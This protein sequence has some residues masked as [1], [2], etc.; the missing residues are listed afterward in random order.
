MAVPL[1]V[2][3]YLSSGAGANLLSTGEGLL[4]SLTG[5]KVKPKGTPFNVV[6]GNLPKFFHTY[7]SGQIGGASWRPS[8]KSG[9]AVFDAESGIWIRNIDAAFPVDQRKKIEATA[10]KPCESVTG[11]AALFMQPKPLQDDR[12]I[13]QLADG[14][15]YDAAMYNMDGGTLSKP[16]R[17]NIQPKGTKYADTGQ[18]PHAS[19]SP[20]QAG[21]G[22]LGLLAL[23]GLYFFGKK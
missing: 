12:G 14:Q 20:L 3:T 23:A 2:S 17:V 19:P 18:I 16:V 8:E 7:G 11:D 9:G 1:M 4:S 10:R 21:G 13:L 6:A 15:L 22:A 5:C